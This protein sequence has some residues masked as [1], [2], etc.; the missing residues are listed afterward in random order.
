M[1]SERVRVLVHQHGIR[2]KQP[3]PVV[4]SHD[5]QY[6]PKGVGRR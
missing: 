6:D 4:H 2:L 5:P 1:S 3:T